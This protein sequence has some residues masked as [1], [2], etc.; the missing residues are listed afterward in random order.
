MKKIALLVILA[1]VGVFAWYYWETKPKPN[2]EV[3]FIK[4]VKASQHSDFFNNSVD[5]LLNNYYAVSESLVAWDSGSLQNQT[6]QLQKSISAFSL[7]E[8]EKDTALYNRAQTHLKAVQEQGT[9]FGNAK[10]LEAK[11]RAFHGLSQNLYNLLQSVQYDAAKVY[12]QE[13][14]MAFNDEETGNWLSNT[15]QIRNPYLGLHHPKYKSGMLQ[16]G[17]VA[18]SLVFDRVQ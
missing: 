17:E 2:Q 16:C 18:D 6:V 13:C 7:Q 11:R 15:A 10:G 1:L 8:L 9:A 12:L 14:P 3:N 5:S 4:P